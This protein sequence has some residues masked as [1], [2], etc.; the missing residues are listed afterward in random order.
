M[1]Q[2][3]MECNIRERNRMEQK[4]MELNTIEWNETEQNVI[5]AQKWVYS[6][7]LLNN[8]TAWNV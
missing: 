2:N 3:R 8:K 7:T 5:R 1:E 6:M 4:R